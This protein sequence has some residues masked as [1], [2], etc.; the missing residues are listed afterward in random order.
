MNLPVAGVGSQEPRF[1]NAPR[2]A[3]RHAD[4]AA[5]L[6]AGYGLEPDD[7]QR[8]T[9]RAWLSET[10]GKWSSG[11]CGLAVPRQNG[12]NAVLEM[13]ELYKMVV[14]GR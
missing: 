2:G 14:L 13:V 3:M 1:C 9:L 12:K 11:R 6:A 10:A 7:W 8:L 4:D 5:F